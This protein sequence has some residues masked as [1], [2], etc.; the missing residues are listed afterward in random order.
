[1]KWQQLLIN[2]YR[3]MTQEI[4]HVLDGLAVA[5]LHQRPSPGANPIGWLIWHVTRSMDRTLGDAVLGKQL[6]IS[7]GWHKKFGMSPDPLD[8]GYGHTD[9]RVDA[10]KIPDVKT[11][12]DY[13]HAVMNAFIKRIETLTETDLDKE[14]PSSLEPGARRAFHLRLTSNMHDMMHVGQAGYVRGLIKG[15]R[16]YGR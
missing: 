11:L 2:N 6:W 10:L 3:R 16:W 14:Y 1:M 8:T 4:E 9:A 5:D 12:L 7:E 13:H 15:H